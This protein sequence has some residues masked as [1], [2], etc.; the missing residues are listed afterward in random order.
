MEGDKTS[1]TKYRFDVQYADDA[2]NETIDNF[3]FTYAG[4]IAGDAANGTVKTWNNLQAANTYTVD[5]GNSVNYV[6]AMSWTDGDG[7]IVTL[8]YGNGSEDYFK[9]TI[10]GV[11]DRIKAFKDSN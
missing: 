4:N 3:T 1:S 9:I 6:T 8:S 2:D 10:N 11:E 5:N 7:K